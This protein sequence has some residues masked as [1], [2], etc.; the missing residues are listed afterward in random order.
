L[1]PPLPSLT[2][3]RLPWNLEA[4][5]ATLLQRK[6][7]EVHVTLQVFFDLKSRRKKFYNLIIA[8]KSQVLEEGLYILSEP[9]SKTK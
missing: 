8:R 7:E 2:P 5:K 3:P 1:N 6:E 9:K 4:L